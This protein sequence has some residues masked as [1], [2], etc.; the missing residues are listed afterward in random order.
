MFLEPRV[1]TTGFDINPYTQFC[2]VTALFGK[3]EVVTFWDSIEHLKTPHTIIQALSPEYLFVCTPS[4][5]DSEHITKWR[6]YMPVEHCHY[7]NEQSLVALIKA[8]GYEI[9]EVN[10]N[11]SGPRDGGGDKNILTIAAKRT[12]GTH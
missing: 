6:H 12:H 10:Y 4:T 11:E 8:C 2:D 5:D 7:F 1:K 3:Y 9:L